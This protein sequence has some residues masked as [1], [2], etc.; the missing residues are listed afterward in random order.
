M[1]RT[2]STHDRR[3]VFVSITVDGEAMAKRSPFPLQSR[4]IDGFQKMPELEQATLTLAVERLVSL[5]GAGDIDAS[6]ILDL[7][8]IAEASDIDNEEHHP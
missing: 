8:P 4:L 2:R 1:S 3:Q 5:M 7:Q 6:A